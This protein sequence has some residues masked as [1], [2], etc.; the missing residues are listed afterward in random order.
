MASC[1]SSHGEPKESINSYH[2]DGPASYLEFWAHSPANYSAPNKKSQENARGS[3]NEGP[4]EPDVGSPSERRQKTIHLR[5]LALKSWCRAYVSKNAYSSKRSCLTHKEL[6]LIPSQRIFHTWCALFPETP[7][8]EMGNETQTSLAKTK[9][10]SLKRPWNDVHTREIGTRKPLTF[11]I[12]FLMDLPTIQ[13][14][15]V[16]NLT[17]IGL[18]KYKK[19]YVEVHPEVD[20]N[21]TKT[22]SPNCKCWKKDKCLTPI[23]VWTN[24]KNLQCPRHMTPMKFSSIRRPDGSTWEYWKRKEPISFLKQ[25]R[26]AQ[27]KR[28]EADSPYRDLDYSGYRKKRI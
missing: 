25:C 21:I 9:T 4:N 22:N 26:V 17:A 19:D 1:V 18:D 5:P 23:N 2:P 28:A 20:Q 27:W 14:G 3:Q 16:T 13:G 7:R 10:H 8:N 24:W 12:S 6:D 15:V 11:L